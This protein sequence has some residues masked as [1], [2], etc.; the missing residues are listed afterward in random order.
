MR[1]DLLLVLTT[2]LIS[3]FYF[4]LSALDIVCIGLVS[5][6]VLDIGVLTI[7]LLTFVFPKHCRYL[8]P[9]ISLL[10]FTL[11]HPRLTIYTG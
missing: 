2:L 8:I 9:L 3:P 7:A 4:Y 1:S 6:S 10:P 5:G 11:L